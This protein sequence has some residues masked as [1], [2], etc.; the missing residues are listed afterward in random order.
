[1]IPRV[2]LTTLTV[3]F[4]AAGAARAQPE[5]GC[6]RLTFFTYAG[7]R[8]AVAANQLDLFKESVQRKVRQLAPPA[9]ADLH[10]ITVE[11]T[12]PP[13]ED[14]RRRYMTNNDALALIGGMISVRDSAPPTLKNEVF[15][16]DRRGSLP[17]QY[18]YLDLAY[19]DQQYASMNDAVSAVALYALAME[20][21]RIRGNRAHSAQMLFT[22]LNIITNVEAKNEGG[23]DVAVLHQAIAG[24]LDEIK[25][26][27]W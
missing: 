9:Y 3:L 8:D 1:M 22:A 21:R 11:A 17:R 5:K 23:A 16:G 12:L 7:A 4:F 10:L 2:V 13:S 26:G 19:D 20:Q 6:R 27:R 25:G 15:L 18:L 14:T 24:A